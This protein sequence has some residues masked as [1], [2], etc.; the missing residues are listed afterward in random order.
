MRKLLGP[1]DVSFERSSK[2]N[3]TGLRIVCKTTE[4]WEVGTRDQMQ[5]FICNRAPPPEKIK[6]LKTSE[7][8]IPGGFLSSVKLED[9]K[10]SIQALG[11]KTHY[12]P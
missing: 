5:I 12:R 11:T 8:L 4:T 3:W 2:W 9:V 10:V 7:K 6:R 1:K